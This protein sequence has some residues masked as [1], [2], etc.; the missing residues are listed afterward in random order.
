MALPTPEVGLVVRYGFVWK[1]A[2]RQVLDAGK[3]RPCLIADVREQDGMTRVVYLPISHVTPSG[4]EHAFVLAP[5]VQR[6][7]G[8]DWET[9]YLYTSYACEDDWPYDL[10]KRPGTDDFD[11]GFIPPKLFGLVAAEFARRLN[12]DPEFPNQR[13]G[14]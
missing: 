5:A 8:L 3:D 2:D 10:A 13:A 7:L 1:S 9:S 6:H 14:D 4:E 12:A 11:Y